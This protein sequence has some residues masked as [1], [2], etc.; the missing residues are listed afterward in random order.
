MNFPKPRIVVSKCIE[1]EHCRYNGNIISSDVVKMMIPHVEFITVCPEVEIGLGIPREPIRLVGDESENRLMQPSTKKDVTED[2]RNFAEKFLDGL[3]PVDGFLFK[4][5]SPS[6]GPQQ[7]KIYPSMEK[8]PSL[9]KNGV[10]HFAMAVREK[11]SSNAIEDEGRLTNFTIRENYFSRI[12]T[13]AAFREA[14]AKGQMA[15]LVDFHSR[16]KL[17]LLA[18]NQEK[19]REMGRITA[20]SEKK[21]VAEVIEE[22]RNVLLT[23][24]REPPSTGSNVN[25]LQH[26]F[27]YFKNSVSKEEKAYFIDTLDKY[28]EGRIPLSVPVGIVRSFIVRFGEDYLAQQ[29]F[30]EPYPIELVA[31]SDSGKGREL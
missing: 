17:L 9:G 19:M 4:S 5:S 10:G 28:V 31:I 27:G 7:V 26:A 24:F 6:C 25:V 12:F 11:F 23:T 2:M 20:N 29:A 21:P 22:Y 3:P 15:D 13:I 16:Y 1:F 8:V 14:T 30:F 18:Q